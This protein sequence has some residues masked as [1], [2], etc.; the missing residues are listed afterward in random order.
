MNNPYVKYARSAA[1]GAQ[2]Q[3]QKENQQQPRYPVNFSMPM[4]PYIQ[5][6]SGDLSNVNTPRM[7]SQFY[8]G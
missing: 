1:Q 8:G 2:Q 4:M 7:G 3:R 6:P 5:P